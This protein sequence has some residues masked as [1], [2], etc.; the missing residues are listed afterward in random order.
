LASYDI[1]LAQTILSNLL[2]GNIN[3]VWPWQVSTGADKCVAFEN[4]EQ[5]ANWNQNIIFAN[6]WLALFAVPTVTVAIAI[7]VTST[8]TVVA[9]EATTA[10]VAI[11][12]AAII[13]GLWR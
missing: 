3:I 2:Q 5:A 12:S 8:P 9:I 11:V 1:S 13:V 4:I 7:A 6:D 10:V